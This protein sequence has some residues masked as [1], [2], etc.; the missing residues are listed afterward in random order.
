[1]MAA[2][3]AAANIIPD[4]NW[5]I[6][7][8][9]A[10]KVKVAEL[11]AFVQNAQSRNL[12][13]LVGTEMNAYGQRFVDDFDA[14]E[15]APLHGVFLEGAHIFHAHTMLQAGASMGYLSEWASRHFDTVRAKNVFYASVGAGVLTPPS[16]ALESVGL[17]TN[18]DA[19][20]VALGVRA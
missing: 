19:V 20:A 17:D 12:P 11:N 2:G 18:P 16:G 14:P 8:P 6:K 9:E 15:L 5:N 10:K 13:I 1:M 4:R 7:D 3:A